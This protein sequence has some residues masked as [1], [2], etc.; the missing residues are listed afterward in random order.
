MLQYFLFYAFNRSVAYSTV[1]S[2]QNAGIQRDVSLKK[3][4]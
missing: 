1:R 3:Q 2:T 4:A